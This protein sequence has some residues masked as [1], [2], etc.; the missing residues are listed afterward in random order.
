MHR[1][2]ESRLRRPAQTR[3]FGAADSQVGSGSSKSKHLSLPGQLAGAK[4]ESLPDKPPAPPCCHLPPRPH[5]AISNSY[6][7]GRSPGVL[8]TREHRMFFR[9]Y[10]CRAPVLSP[11]PCCLAVT[12]GPLDTRDILTTT[13]TYTSSNEACSS[14]DLT[15][16]RGHQNTRQHLPPKLKIRQQ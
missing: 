14:P 11:S 12:R 7:E 2:T 5:L 9:W 15:R 1:F 16:K 4:I 8:S 6:H 3:I 10:I 13:H